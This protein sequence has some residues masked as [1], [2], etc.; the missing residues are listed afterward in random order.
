MVAL[1]TIDVNPHPTRQWGGG[2][3]R[4]PDLRIGVI[5]AAVV[6]TQLGVQ[7]V[8]EKIYREVVLV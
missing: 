6:A 2:R 8:V 4:P 7:N 3:N 5:P 1:F